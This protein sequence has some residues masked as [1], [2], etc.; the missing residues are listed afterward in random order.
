MKI[1]YT[2]IGLR[3]RNRRVELNM[4]QQDLADQTNYSIQY[5]RNIERGHTKLGFRA[6]ILI[7]EALG[8]SVDTLLF[9]NIDKSGFHLKYELAKII[10]SASEIQTMAID[11][12][13]GLIVKKQ[14]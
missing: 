11:E 9:D 5:I 8:I 7:S 10:N 1:D 4:S 14:F 12:I 3:I 13:I 6:I 2:A